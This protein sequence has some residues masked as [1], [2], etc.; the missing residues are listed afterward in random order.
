MMEPLAAAEEVEVEEEAAADAGEGNEEEER[1]E[2]DV[3]RLE[4]PEEPLS[5]YDSRRME[6]TR[7]EY[8]WA[9][10]L[11]EAVQSDPELDVIS[12]FMLTQIAVVEE[13]NMESAMDRV[14]K[15]QHYRQEYDV[16]DS[17]SESKRRLRELMK[18]MPGHILYLGFSPQ[19]SNYMLALDFTKVKAS[20]FTSI[21]ATKS[22]FAGLY[23]LHHTIN[24]DMAAV[25][26]GAIFLTEWEGYAWK[27]PQLIDL[28]I[29]K[30]CAMEVRN[31]PFSLHV[32]KLYHS[33]VLVN[34]M[35]SAVRRCCPPLKKVEM[36]CDDFGDRLDKI[37]MVPNEEEATE[38]C[39]QLMVQSLHRRYENERTFRL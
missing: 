13:G 39:Y 11:K 19:D 5:Q 12:D 14:Y 16:L 29:M 27:R 35:V 28:K 1:G 4:W 8:Q 36:G 17:F 23:Y 22:Y 26:H 33:G 2:R 7:D 32:C 20:A 25:R 37:F 18:L 21:D 3:V 31:Y 24:P 15:L 6:L 9:V 10:S 34:T 38:R 30:R